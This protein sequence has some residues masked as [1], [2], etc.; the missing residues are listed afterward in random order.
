VNPN[1]ILIGIA[2]GI[3][4][5]LLFAAV[6]GG[7]VLG[8]PLFALAPLPI[9]IASLGWGTLAGLVAGGVGSLV[10]AL[11]ATP[12]AGL[13][14][15]V[16][17]GAPMAW[18]G[19]L[20]GLA[21]PRDA[22]VSEAGLEWY[23]LARVFAAMVAGTA[24][25]VLVVGFLLDVSVDEVAA[26]M[27]DALLEMAA[28]AGQADMPPRDQLIETTRFYV[29]LM[30]ATMSMLWLAMAGF[31]L[32]L[33]GRIVRVSGRLRRP[34][35]PTPETIALPAGLIVVLLGAA[36]FALAGGTL[37]LAAGAIAG[38]VGMAFAILGFAVIHV[39]TRGN[40]ARQIILAVLYGATFV[41]SLP[42]LPVALLG[43]ADAAFG[44]RGKRLNP[45]SGPT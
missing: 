28:E 35:E 43:M 20:A 39:R 29:R 23:P 3:A 9:A 45:G 27:A 24:A 6:L 37:G 38:T 11:L 12:M 2:G 10:L 25:A 1:A 8:V 34:W 19:H 5:A 14:F 21:R 30:P 16:L 44:L 40:P 4:A 15:L 22:A 32:W 13:L 26:T 33:A 42:L 18:Y 7:G 31:N 17:A 41:F 36:A